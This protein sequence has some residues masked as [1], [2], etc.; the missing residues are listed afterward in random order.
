MVE[1]WSYELEFDAEWVEGEA[2]HKKLSSNGVDFDTKSLVLEGYRQELASSP[3]YIPRYY[4]APSSTVI[5]WSN[6]CP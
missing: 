1:N 6:Y 2:D 3:E 5:R 4:C